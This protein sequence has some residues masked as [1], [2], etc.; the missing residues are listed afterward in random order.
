LL[1]DT[2]GAR[3]ILVALLLIHVG[4]ALYL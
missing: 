4:R 2:C 3:L 1:L